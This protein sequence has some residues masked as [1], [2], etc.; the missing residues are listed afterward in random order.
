[1]AVDDRYGDPPDDETPHE[2]LDRNT[3]EFLNEL[4]VFATG[5]Q[6]VFAF[7][8][9]VPFNQGFR[10]VTGFERD[11]YFGTL[12]CVAIAT[13]LLIAP[14]VHYRVLFHYHERR[15]VIETGNRIAVTATAFQAVGF[16]GIMLLLADYVLGA[17]AAAVVTPV[18]AT[19]VLGLWFVAP[20]VRRRREMAGDPGP[21]PP[22]PSDQSQSGA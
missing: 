1:M 10:H 9:V 21:P 22:A 8:L 14:S 15:W 5:I 13:T 18:G 20:I 16:V 7:L 3:I 17:V 6:V 11:V 4:R 2:R 12:L 19:F